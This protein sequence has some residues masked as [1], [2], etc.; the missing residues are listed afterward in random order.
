MYITI[1]H[2]LSL[3]NIKLTFFRNTYST[4]SCYIHESTQTC[5]KNKKQIMPINLLMSSIVNLS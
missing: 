1:I 5:T 3:I 2:Y 4:A